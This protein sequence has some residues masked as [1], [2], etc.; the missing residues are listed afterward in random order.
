MKELQELLQ[1]TNK[2]TYTSKTCVCIL[3][4]YKSKSERVK[5]LPCFVS[6]CIAA[7]LGAWNLE[8]Q[9]RM[10]MADL[11]GALRA[12]FFMHGVHF[13]CHTNLRMA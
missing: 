11:F 6:K 13:N 2:V 3:E 4:L 12:L 5:V 10:N 8:A 1:L 7:K 9:P